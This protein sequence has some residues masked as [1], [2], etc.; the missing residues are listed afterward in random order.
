MI[1]RLN[2]NLDDGSCIT[3][4]YGCIDSLYLEFDSLAN[5]DD[6]SCVNLI[7]EGCTDPTYLEY[8]V[9]YSTLLEIAL[10][11]AI[12]NNDDGSCEV[13]LGEGCTKFDIV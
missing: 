5:T 1:H 8:W 12:A 6:G 4:E 3:F 11:S 7:V 10:P 9:Y 2:A 13:K